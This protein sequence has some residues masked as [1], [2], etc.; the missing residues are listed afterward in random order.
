MGKECVIEP[1]MEFYEGYILGNGMGTGPN[2]IIDLQI[3]FE[4][5]YNKEQLLDLLLL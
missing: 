4:E 3:V 2:Y 1:G 5:I